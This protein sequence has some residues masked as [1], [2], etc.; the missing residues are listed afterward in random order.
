MISPADMVLFATV[1]REGSFTRAARRT[2]ITKQTVSERIAKLEAELRVRLLERTTRSLR[3]TDAGAI[4]AQRCALIAARIDEANAELSRR[5]LEPV[6]ALRVSTP[7]LYGRRFLAP[8]VTD[9]LRRF[10]DVRIEVLLADRR[11][12]LIEE[13]FDLAIRVGDLEDSSLSAKKLGDGY[14]HYVA[15]PH[16][17]A[18]HGAPKPTAMGT[19]RCIGLSR[20]ETWAVAGAQAKVEPVLVVNDL[21]MACDA[22]IAG[23][24]VARLPSLVCRDAVHDGRLQVL[25]ATTQAQVRPV[26]AVYPSRAYLPAKV[27]LFVEALATMIEPM[28]PIDVDRIGPRRRGRQR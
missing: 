21:E 18:R 17:V 13:G 9:Y 3:P 2:G 16:F 22:A 8:V 24:G 10:P 1:V 23:V 4:Y 11:V 20:Q 28:L 25:F 26:Y 12:N 5:H 6:G 7:V 14:V 27:R 19:T 15:S